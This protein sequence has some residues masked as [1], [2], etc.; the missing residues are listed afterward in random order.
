MPMSAEQLQAGAE[1][2]RRGKLDLTPEKKAALGELL[3][4][5]KLPPLEVPEATLNQTDPQTRAIDERIRLQN[6]AVKNMNT[7]DPAA[8]IGIMDVPLQA[9]IAAAQNNISTAGAPLD[10]RFNVSFADNP[11]QAAKAELEKRFNKP[12]QVRTGPTNRLEFSVDGGQFT[13]FNPP[14]FDV[15]DIAGNTGQAITTAGDIAGTTGGAALGAIAGVPALGAGLGSGAGTFLTDI[16]RQLIANGLD[17]SD[18]DLAD[19][20]T[21]AGEKAGIAAIATLGTGGLLNLGKGVLNRLKGRVFNESNQ[22]LGLDNADINKTVQDINQKAPGFAPRA[23]QQGSDELRFLDD[24]FRTST[25]LGKTAKFREQDQKNM[26]LLTEFEARMSSKFEGNALDSGNKVSGTIK[27]QFQDNKIARVDNIVE[28]TANKAETVGNKIPRTDQETLG[29][30]IRGVAEKE[31]QALR[32]TFGAQFNKFDRTDITSDG[33]IIANFQN[34]I[35]AAQKTSATPALHS[36]D[37]AL[38]KGG[39]ASKIDKANSD[40]ADLTDSLVAGKN[41]APFVTLADIQG[42]LRKINAQIRAAETGVANYNSAGLQTLKGLKAAYKSQRQVMLKDHPE[43]LNDLN[44]LELQFKVAKDLVDRSIIGDIAKIRKGKPV[45]NNQKLFSAIISP[46]KVTEAKRFADAIA[47]K[48]EVKDQVR[49][50]ILDLYKQKVFKPEP[51]LGDVE[52]PSI[53]R[54]KAFMD[55]YGD[56]IEP[57]L[58]QSE[59]DTISSTG[60]LARQMTRQLK[61]RQKI[62]NV[63][64]TRFSA[65]LTNLDPENIAKFALD[66]KKAGRSLQLRRLIQTDPEL[67]SAVRTQAAHQIRRDIMKDGQFHFTKVDKLLEGEGANNVA[68]IMGPQYLKD[69]KTLRDGL[70]LIQKRSGLTGSAPEAPNTVIGNIWRAIVFPPLSRGGRAFTAVQEGRRSLTTDTLGDALESPEKLRAIINARNLD[71]KTQRAAQILSSVG[72]INLTFDNQP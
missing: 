62:V 36:N 27:K 56:V 22:T 71:P 38:T 58:T 19:I 70:E 3:K 47:D 52:L 9:D 6:E 26:G 4:R 44:N 14:G 31:Q 72:L 10:T 32:D 1:L 28:N 21:T 42:D 39:I 16:A 49:K 51:A 34:K 67:M 12:V 7:G 37:V 8:D 33:Q 2:Y 17:V 41:N 20:V 45:I 64:K 29:A 18:K 60:M 63:L 35:T 68:N 53:K 30:N 5:N 40:L 55:Q 69:L 24:K 11:E 66:N 65:K 59:R 57:F 54:H 15:G 48:P 13:T 43:V 23:S 46:G 50:A 61:A 25:T